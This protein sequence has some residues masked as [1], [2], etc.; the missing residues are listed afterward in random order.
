VLKSAIDKEYNH[1][2]IA[3]SGG[4]DSTLLSMLIMELMQRKAL[5]NNLSSKRSLPLKKKS[6]KGSILPKKAVVCL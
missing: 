1:W 3:Y 4:K 5:P 6:N 2:V